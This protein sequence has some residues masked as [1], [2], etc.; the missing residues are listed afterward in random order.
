LSNGEMV[1]SYKRTKGRFNNKGR[2]TTVKGNVV[3][4]GGTTF[5]GIMI[6]GMKCL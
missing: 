4:K 5:G 1:M 2:M 3:Y 6:R